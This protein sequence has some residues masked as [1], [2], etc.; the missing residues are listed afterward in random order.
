[1]VFVFGSVIVYIEVNV[2]W[3]WGFGI[4]FGVLVVGNFVFVLGSWLYR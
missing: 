3:D 1:M 2:G 4:F